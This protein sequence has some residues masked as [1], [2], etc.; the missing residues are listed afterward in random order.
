[1]HA[2]VWLAMLR[3][4]VWDVCIAECIVQEQ[5]KLEKENAKENVNLRAA[6]AAADGTSSGA[7]GQSSSAREEPDVNQD[8]LR[9]VSLRSRS[10][11]GAFVWRS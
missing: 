6:A 2:C 5:E 7:A 4:A 8:H 9:Q 3:A 10:T 1:M 11:D